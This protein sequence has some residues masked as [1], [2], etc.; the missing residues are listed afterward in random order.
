MT[1]DLSKDLEQIVHDSDSRELCRAQGRS[2]HRQK[3]GAVRVV[4][5]PRG[6]SPLFGRRLDHRHDGGMA[7][8][9]SLR[10]WTF[11]PS[12]TWPLEFFNVDLSPHHAGAVG[13]DGAGEGSP[14]PPERPLTGS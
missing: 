4:P 14:R 7:E 9:S 10:G 6:S 1:I 13:W 8:S 5:I 3:R 11:E 2:L 12:A